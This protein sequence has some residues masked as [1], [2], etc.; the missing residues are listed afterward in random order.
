MYILGI[1]A[2]HGDSAAAIMQDGRLLAAV[3]EERINRIKHWAGLPIGSVK[4][5]LDSAGIKLQDLDFIAVSRNPWARFHK[6][7]FRSVLKTPKPEFLKERGLNFKKIL[8][9]KKD[10]ALALGI[11]ERE[12]K[13][14]LVNVEHHRSHLASSF[15]VSP[16]ATAA[17]VSIDGFGDFA[18]ATVGMGTGNK[19]TIIDTVG[20]PHSLG[21]FYTAL[22][23]F[24][25][26]W[27]YGDEY[28]VM[29]LAAFGRPF[30]LNQM[31]KIVKLKANGLFEL[32]TTYFLHQTLSAEMSWLNQG[33]KVGKLFSD[34]LNRL[35]GGANLADLA[36]SVQA[37][38]EEAF[39]HV[40]NHLYQRTET[41][42]LALAGGCVQNSS[43][44][45]KIT[46]RT[47]FKEV[48]V[49]PAAHDAGTAAG[50]AFYVW[51]Q[52]LKHPRSFVMDSPYWG[53]EFSE[54]EIEKQL[55]ER[56]LKYKKL[57]DGE[58]LTKTA[59]L[60]ASGLIV[61]WF[62]GKTEFGP[63]A[64]GNR[65]IFASPQQ[66][67]T[68]DILNVQIKHREPF[69]P[70]G[71]S[72]VQESAADYFEGIGSDPF[73]SRTY[74]IRPEKMKYIPAVAHVDGTS[75]VQ[76]VSRKA[77]PKF[78]DLLQQY[79]KITGLPV[80][81]NTSF[82]DNEPIVNQPGEAIDCFLRTKMDALV[83]GNYLLLR[84]EQ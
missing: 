82:N 70:F 25:G 22:A 45:G 29:A 60:L 41:S 65:S 36:A 59:R 84:D 13:A 43:A 63:R 66:T 50:S 10:L 67:A 34:K 44:N 58:L 33:P 77:N 47:G 6:K 23:Q 14:K 24:L 61:G 62:Q 52:V 53:R 72:V 11:P 8:D 80:L 57:P 4:F 64:L 69:R 28:K 15:F 78:W 68:K 55:I 74:R 75:R 42:K 21:I 26:F 71:C 46:L 39:F 19:I 81:L 49:P 76:T 40:L 2:Y 20:F 30:Y 48:Y 83:V 31:R 51:N 16:F 3:E 5:C 37:M 32:D 12:I 56:H 27:N 1:N 73:M 18:S 54:P 9:I 38:Y 35:I 17:V 79:S 7:L